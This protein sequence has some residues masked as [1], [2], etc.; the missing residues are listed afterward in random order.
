MDY[1]GTWTL[2]ILA[3]GLYNSL[4]EPLDNAMAYQHTGK[5]WQVWPLLSERF[6]VV[7]DFDIT[8]GSPTVAG[9]LLAS[10]VEFLVWGFGLV[11]VFGL[12][13]DRHV[14]TYIHMFMC[15]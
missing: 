15:L 11:L 3:T 9:G 1:H 5:S 7:A 8:V 10:C 12:G 14:Y 6:P 4:G 13:S 2:L